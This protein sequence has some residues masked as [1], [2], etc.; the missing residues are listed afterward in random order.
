MNALRRQILAAQL[1]VTLDKE[2][3][4]TTSPKVIELSKRDL[5]PLI[6]MKSGDPVFMARPEQADDQTMT[7]GRSSS[8]QA[9]YVYGH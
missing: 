2:L 1:K 6:R 4:R 9:G 8:Q 5:P 7:A 3:G